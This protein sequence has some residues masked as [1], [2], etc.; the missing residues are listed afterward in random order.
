IHQPGVARLMRW[1]LLGQVIASNCPPIPR[2]RLDFGPFALEGAAPPLDGAAAAYAPRRRVL[3]NILVQAAVS[4][5]AELREHFSVQELVLDGDCVT[6]IRGQGLGGAM[7]TE[8]AC[9][10]IGADGQRSL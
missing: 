4:A 10:V 1:G 9:I 8:A 6:G 7:V 3:D 5:G 2:L